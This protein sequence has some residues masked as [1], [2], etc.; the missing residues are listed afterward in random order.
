MH[1]ATVVTAAAAAAAAAAEGGGEEEEELVNVRMKII[2]HRVVQAER[3]RFTQDR[4][5]RGDEG[6]GT[7][8]KR[9]TYCYGILLSGHYW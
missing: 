7:E 9:T 1:R 5:E 4:D 3:F 8:R 6:G 2:A